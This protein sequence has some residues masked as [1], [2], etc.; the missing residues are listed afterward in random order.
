MSFDVAAVLVFVVIGRAAHSKGETLAGIASTAWPF[1]VALGGGW[2]ASRA[3][4]RPSA[5]VR[6]GFVA[7]VVCVA[8]GMLLRLLAGQGTAPAFVL[9][10]LGFLGATM[11][12]WRLAY[13]L[14]RG[15]RIARRLVSLR[16]ALELS[17]LGD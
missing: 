1:L 13:L 12:G 14:S 2:L 3:W 9:V 10:A 5:L 11:E 16:R 6:T 15:L 8:G 4:R 7:V 17:R